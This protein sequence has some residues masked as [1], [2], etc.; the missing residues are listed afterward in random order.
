MRGMVLG[1]ILSWVCPPLGRRGKIADGPP[2]LTSTKGN[3]MNRMLLGIAMA[4]ATH[5]GLGQGAVV[6]NN[7]SLIGN[8]FFAPTRT[9]RCAGVPSH[10]V[11]T[12]YIT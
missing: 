1:S 2:S 7:R 4:L 6:F 9:E 11:N 12:N 5:N 3:A 8:R 10:T